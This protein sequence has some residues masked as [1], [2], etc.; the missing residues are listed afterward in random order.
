[1]FHLVVV[2]DCVGPCLTLPLA[3]QIQQRIANVKYVCILNATQQ[4]KR[5]EGNDTKLKLKW[6]K[7]AESDKNCIKNRFYRFSSFTNS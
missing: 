1:M 5:K 6:E 4:K 3:S 2:V 7:E